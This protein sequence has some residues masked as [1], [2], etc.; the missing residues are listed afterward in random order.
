MLRGAERV[1][2]ADAEN[3]RAP[4]RKPA[5]DRSRRCRSAWTAARCSSARPASACTTAN[6]TGRRQRTRHAG[7]LGDGAAHLRRQGVQRD[8]LAARP[9]PRSC[10]WRWT[11][12]VWP[13]RRSC[14]S[15][16]IIAFARHPRSN[17][18][19]ARTSPAIPG[20]ESGVDE[21]Y[22]ARAAH[23]RRRQTRRYVEQLA[24][25]FEPER[26]TTARPLRARGS[27]TAGCALTGEAGT[28]VDHAAA[29][30]LAGQEV[31]CVRR[32]RDAGAQD[33]GHGW[34]S[35]RSTGRRMTS[36]SASLIR[37]YL[38]DLPRNLQ[39]T[40]AKQKRVAEADVHVLHA[41]GGRIRLL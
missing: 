11:M 9:A 14:R 13:R 2:R 4:F 25:Y 27:S 26:S 28:N 7:D 3:H 23:D 18:L 32:R 36:R 1:R 31:A 33:R 39:G 17:F 10:G 19:S 6:T 15:R 37:G 8:G 5:R 22:H 38:R 16:S 21:V 12:A 30:H 29:L 41:G 20:V 35:S 40:T 24:D 34:Q